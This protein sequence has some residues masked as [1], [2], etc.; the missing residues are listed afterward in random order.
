V[1]ARQKA[2]GIGGAGTPIPAPG[3]TI[4]WVATDDIPFLAWGQRAAILAGA[5]HPAAAKLYLNWQLSTDVQRATPTGWSVRTDVAPAAGLK[6]IWDHPNAHLEQFD[7]FMA[8]RAEV[9][10]WRQN[11]TLYFGEVQGAPGPGWLGLHPGRPVT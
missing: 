4:R 8:D 7:Q 6:P 3:S 1:A 2:I 10:R 11:L 5:A 9:E